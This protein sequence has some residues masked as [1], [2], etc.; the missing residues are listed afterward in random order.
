MKSRLQEKFNLLNVD[1]L[2]VLNG[3][4]SDRD[5]QICNN[6][7]E[8][9]REQGILHGYFGTKCNNI[10]NRKRVTYNAI[11][12]LY[13]YYCFEMF[14][15]DVTPEEQETFR[16]L[17][18]F[19]YMQGQYECMKKPK[20]ISDTLYYTLL[21]TPCANGYTLDEYKGSKA[22]NSTYQIH[23][24]ATMQIQRGQTPNVSEMDREI[25]KEQNE[26]LKVGAK[27]SG[28]IDMILIGINNMA[29]V[30]GIKEATKRAR[31]CKSTI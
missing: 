2:N 8:M 9:W 26:R 10:Y 17:A 30:E 19:Y 13:I 15:T 25:E 12:E 28:V 16:D 31:R 4:A 14:E 6:F 23:R 5:K 1:E 21:D 29:K 24:Q 3:Y 22:L 7:I 20:Q 27:I 18:N 11:L